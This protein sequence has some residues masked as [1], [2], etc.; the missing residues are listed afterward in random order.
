MTGNSTTK[1]KNWKLSIQKAQSGD[2][3]ERDAFITEN[4]GL[5]YMV[6]KRFK[7]RGHE[8]EDLFQIGV[9]GLMKAVDKF[10]T[11]TDFSFSTYA[12]PMIIGEIR[13]F[14][15]DDGMLHISRK[16]KD[17]E[18][19]IAAAKER[20][21]KSCQGEPTMEK[22]MEETGLTYEEIL[23]AIEAS[24]DVESIYRPIGNGT[25][26]HTLVLAD[27]LV[28]TKTK[29]SDLINQI[30]VKQM[31]QSLDNKERKLI[32]LRYMEG[33][34]QSESAK[35]LGMNQVAVSRLEKKILLRLRKQCCI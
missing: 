5:V 30:T 26:E 12:V 21:S 17:D 27:Q 13:R 23:V 10:D 4:V 9:I 3:K 33:K 19:K 18:I 11:T 28:D 31:L 7:N 15:R 24:A 1:E 22:I 25:D 20:I 2:K 29:E 8:V 16:I 6:L 35:V 14:L 34:T 32:E